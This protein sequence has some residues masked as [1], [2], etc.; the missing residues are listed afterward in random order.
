MVLASV[1]MGC[2]RPVAEPVSQPN[3][4]RREQAARRMIRAS[5]GALA[6]VYGPLAEQIVEDFDLG[7]KT[8][9]GIDVGSGPGTLI[10]ELCKHTKL[11]WINADINPHFFP[12]FFEQAEKHGFGHRVSVVFADAKRLPFRCNYADVIVSRGSF[13]LWGDKTKALGE[14]YRVLKPGATAYIGRGLSRNLPLKTARKVRADQ[15]GGPRYDVDKTG[16][17]L[18]RIMQELSVADYR[19]HRPKA[20]AP[21]NYGVWVEFHKPVDARPDK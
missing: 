19:I 9:I 11:H 14:I 4:S 16:A 21:V 6:P 18:R 1:L 10:I 17:E 8:G 20:D 3:T 5:R 7:Q 13:H 15:G 2:S 12:H